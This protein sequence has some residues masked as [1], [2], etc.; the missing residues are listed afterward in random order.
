[1]L[2]ALALVC[3]FMIFVYLAFNSGGN[4]SMYFGSAGVLSILFTIIVMVL[5]FQ[6]MKEENSF[7]LFPRLACFFSILAFG[8]WVGTYVFGIVLI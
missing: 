5:A 1:M 3:E 4:L 6:S 2:L 7:K 8:I